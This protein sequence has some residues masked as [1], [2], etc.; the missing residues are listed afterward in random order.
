MCIATAVAVRK[1]ANKIHATRKNVRPKAFLGRLFGFGSW[2]SWWFIRS[3][4]VRIRRKA[5]PTKSG[6]AISVIM[7]QIRR[8][9]K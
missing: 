8:I 2:R 7:P 9:E 6:R 5:W 1:M 4:R 3:S